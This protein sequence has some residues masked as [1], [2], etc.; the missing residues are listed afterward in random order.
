M[1]QIRLFVYPLYLN[2][3]EGFGKLGLFILGSI[4]LDRRHLEGG[5]NT[6]CCL[7]AIEF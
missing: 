4:V 1:T 5:I 6:V 3:S 2:I 7:Y